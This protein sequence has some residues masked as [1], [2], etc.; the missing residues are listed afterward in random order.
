VAI[1]MN[2]GPGT[3]YSARAFAAFREFIDRSEEDR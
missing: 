2:G 3:V 1:L